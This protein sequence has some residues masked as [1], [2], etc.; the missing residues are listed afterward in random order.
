MTGTESA[1]RRLRRLTA[2]EPGRDW[3][4]PARVR[5]IRPVR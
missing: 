2:Y 3:D 4:A 1:A 5:M